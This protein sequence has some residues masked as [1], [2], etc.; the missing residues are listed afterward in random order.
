MVQVIAHRGASKYVPENTMAAFQKA[1]DL[2]C[3]FIECDVGLSQDNIPIIIHDDT[4]DRTTNGSGRITERSY[5]YIKSLDAGSWKGAEFTDLKVPTLQ[6]LLNWHTVTRGW[7]NLEIKQVAVESVP[8][9]VATVLTEIQKARFQENIVISSFQF[10]IMMAFKRYTTFSRVFLSIYAT[11]F[12]ISQALKSNCEQINVSRHW[13]TKEFIE[14][15]HEHGLKVGV[16][17]I[18]H[19]E[20]FI[21]LCDWGIDVVFTDDVLT[22]HT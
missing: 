6:E 19:L 5:E 3:H 12:A 21:K 11:N 13:I 20:E 18:N 10:E 1:H 22:I 7:I 17:T 2:R 16:Y 15:A 8:L 9:I 14:K 4:L